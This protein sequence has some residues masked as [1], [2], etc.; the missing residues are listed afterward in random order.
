M[1]AR[2]KAE[3]KMQRV[4]ARKVPTDEQL[5]GLHVLVDDTLR[6]VAFDDAAMH[7]GWTFVREVE[8][9]C[10]FV[11][12]NPAELDDETA[13]AASLSGGW[14]MAPDSLVRRSGVFIK[15]KNALQVRRKVFVTDAFKTESPSISALLEAKVEDTKVWKFIT[16]IDA[17]ALLKAGAARNKCSATVIALIGGGESDLFAGV[18]HC[19]A[20]QAFLK[21]VTR[22]DAEASSLF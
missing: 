15:F 16:D 5:T 19:F 6:S 8:D 3:V 2:E 14:V 7:L 9:A 21:F 1:V 22:L 18:D 20:L 17:F 4:V 10:V 13:F 12:P 11:V